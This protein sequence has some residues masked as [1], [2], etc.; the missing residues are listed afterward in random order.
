VRFGSGLPFSG[1]LVV[2]ISSQI[3]LL[4]IKVLKWLKQLSLSLLQFSD[5]HSIL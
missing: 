4:P 3:N 1:L 5:S 2:L